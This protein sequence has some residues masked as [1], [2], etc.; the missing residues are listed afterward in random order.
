M[1]KEICRV[2]VDKVQNDGLISTPIQAKLKV[3]GSWV[4]I[5]GNKVEPHREGDPHDKP[6]SMSSGSA[7]LKIG[8]IPVCRQ[9]DPSTCGHTAVSGSSKLRV[10]R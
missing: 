5:V 6:S 2:G 10:L 4:A 7:V 1:A 9:G 8:G 3:E